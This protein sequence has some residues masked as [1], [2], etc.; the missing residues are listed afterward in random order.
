MNWYL[1]KPLNHPG[2]A[3]CGLDGPWVLGCRSSRVGVGTGSQDPEKSLS[4]PDRFS[5][6]FQGTR[7]REVL[8]KDEECSTGPLGWGQGGPR[9]T[10]GFHCVF[11]APAAPTVAQSLGS[12]QREQKTREGKAEKGD[13]LAGTEPGRGGGGGSYAKA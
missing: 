4:L 11:S 8:G 10:Q 5:L 3:R 9:A 13:T 12:S 1:I 2:L 7:F 6:V